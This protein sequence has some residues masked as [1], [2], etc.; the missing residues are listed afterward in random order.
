MLMDTLGALEKFLSDRFKED[1]DES[2]CLELKVRP[3]PASPGRFSWMIEFTG[4]L[5]SDEAEG[6]TLREA[7]LDL[8]YSNIKLPAPLKELTQ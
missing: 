5:Y 1:Q 3:D 7:V 4:H 8:L 6:E 2:L